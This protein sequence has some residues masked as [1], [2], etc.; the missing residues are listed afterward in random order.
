VADE[1]PEHHA[2]GDEPVV[3]KGRNEKL[4]LEE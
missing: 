4:P 1:D 2:G 3:G